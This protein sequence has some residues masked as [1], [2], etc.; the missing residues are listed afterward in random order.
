MVYNHLYILGQRITNL[1][2]LEQVTLVCQEASNNV[3]QY[4]KTR[5]EGINLAFHV[6]SLLRISWSKLLSSEV[7]YFKVGF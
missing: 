3:Y 5:G 2:I 1:S 6:W 4:L 7:Y